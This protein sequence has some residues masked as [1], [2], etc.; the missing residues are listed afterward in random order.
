M[1]LLT[2]LPPIVLTGAVFISLSFAYATNHIHRLRL[3]ED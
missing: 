3:P 2:F 1:L